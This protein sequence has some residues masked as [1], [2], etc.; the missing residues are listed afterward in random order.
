MVKT[1]YHFV[2]VDNHGSVDCFV[3]LVEGKR[4]SWYLAK[5]YGTHRD[6]SLV[7]NLFVGFPVV[8]HK[9]TV[10]TKLIVPID[11]QIVQNKTDPIQKWSILL[12]CGDT[13]P[14]TS[15]LC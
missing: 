8:V 1:F 13:I 9:V 10:L 14:I 15:V 2:V 11:F 6:M 5:N 3:D 4:R 12:H 7:F